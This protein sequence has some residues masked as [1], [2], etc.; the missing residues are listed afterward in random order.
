MQIATRG[1]VFRGRSSLQLSSSCDDGFTFQR[2]IYLFILA[3]HAVESLKS[4]MGFVFI[5]CLQ[6]ATA[7]RAPINML[8]YSWCTLY[9][10]HKKT[11]VHATSPHFTTRHQRTTGTKTQTR[12]APQ[13]VVSA[14]P[15]QQ[16]KPTKFSPTYALPPSIINHAQNGRSGSFQWR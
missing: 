11:Y 6:Q 14:T 2:D 16:Q 12:Q 15:G 5:F 1:D 7:R 13:P 10:I 4:S 3:V 9:N 8:L